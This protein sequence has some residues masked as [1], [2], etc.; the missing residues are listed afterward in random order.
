MKLA[1]CF[2]VF[3]ILACESCEVYAKEIPEWDIPALEAEATIQGW[4]FKPKASWVTEYLR[5]GGTLRNLTGL[6]K[7]P[8]DDARIDDIAP[9][10][11]LPKSFDW[12]LMG[13]DGLQPIRN[14][15]GCGSCWSFS[16]TSVIE[17][18]IKLKVPE[19]KVDLSEQTLVSSCE[20][21]GS[22]SGGYFN[23]FDYIESEG[24]PDESQDPYLAR[25]SSCKSGLEPNMKV[26]RWAYVGRN[27]T[28]EQLKTA[29]VSYGPISVDVNGGFGSYGSGIYNRCGSTSTNH[30][31]T[32]EGWVDD[33]AYEANGG[34]YWIMRNSWGSNW[35]ENGYMRI[36]YKSTAGRNCNGIGNVGAYAVIDD[37]WLDK[38]REQR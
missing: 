32:L 12:R 31:V 20:R 36:V 6:S 14:Q 15:G 16:V 3:A 34:G 11:D 17:G 26:K 24:L 7:A 10:L 2:L 19:A 35:G 9:A 29:I 27:P 38:V 37:T 18:L 1:S 8:I 4:S 5:T 13:L 28:T 23:A 21:A 30:M 25:N 22:C 33:P